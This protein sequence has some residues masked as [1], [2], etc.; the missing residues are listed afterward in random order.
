M[1]A[2]TLSHMTVTKLR[3]E[4]LKFGDISGVHGMDKPELLK[5]L[6]AK[7]GI[8]E[9]KTESEDLTEKKHKIKEDIRKLKAEK[10]EAFANKDK[11]KVAFLQ[12]RLHQQ[13]RLLKKV[14]KLV[15]AA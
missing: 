6:K 13:R 15:K 7:Y 9:K 4:A 5:I 3:D 8:I 1:D 2:N 11:A 10:E 14:V 12:K